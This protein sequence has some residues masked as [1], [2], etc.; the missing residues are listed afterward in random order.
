MNVKISSLVKSFYGFSS[1]KFT[2]RLWLF[3]FE[4][5]NLSQSPLLLVRPDGVPVFPE[6]RLQW[7]PGGIPLAAR[8]GFERQLTPPPWDHPDSLVCCA[9]SFLCCSLQSLTYLLRHLHV[10]RSWFVHDLRIVFG[11]IC[12]GVAHKSATRRRHVPL[13]RHPDEQTR[14]QFN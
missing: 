12:G 5:R 1:F 11:M 3:A 9:V 10:S 7:G 6:K 8:L 14:R 4:F 2:T 13:L